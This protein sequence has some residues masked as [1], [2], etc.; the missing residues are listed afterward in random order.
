[1]VVAA[2]GDGRDPRLQRD[3]L[4]RAPPPPAELTSSSGAAPLPPARSFVCSRHFQ[5]NVTPA[6]S[7]HH[8]HLPPAP[9]P[10]ARRRW[11]GRGG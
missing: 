4:P 9:Q 2:G 6:R 11:G 8:R 10:P 5:A 1:M 7:R 3:P